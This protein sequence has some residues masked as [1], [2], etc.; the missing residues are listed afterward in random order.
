MVSDCPSDYVDQSIV[1]KCRKTS[2]PATFHFDVAVQGPILYYKTFAVSYVV[3]NC[4]YLGFSYLFCTH[5]GYLVNTYLGYLVCTY[6]GYLVCTYLVCTYIGYL[7]CT[8]L[9]YLVCTSLGY[10]VWTSLGY[11]VCTSLGYLVCTYL[12]YIFCIYLDCT[13]LHKYVPDE[14]SLGRQ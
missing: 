7:V 8:Y 9:G 14:L 3:I 4:T 5:Q 13:Y 11:L 1:S 2:F 6:L 10:L 12:G